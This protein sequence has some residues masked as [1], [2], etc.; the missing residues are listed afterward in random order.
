[1]C[2]SNR[3]CKQR[4]KK[5]EK[6]IQKLAR[7]G[8]KGA[9]H[10]QLRNFKSDYVFICH[11]D[12]EQLKCYDRLDFGLFGRSWAPHISWAVVFAR[13]V[14]EYNWREYL[15]HSRSN[16]METGDLFDVV[17]SGSS[18]GIFFFR[19]PQV[20]ILLSVTLMALELW[21]H[22]TNSIR[23]IVVWVVMEVVFFWRL[24]F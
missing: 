5:G 11:A 8:G 22:L 23:I 10:R 16:F 17:A 18:D 20:V 13:G 2:C 21:F 15:P 1:M 3:E 24:I 12:P 7:Y 9:G 6:K 4:E 19:L 14:K